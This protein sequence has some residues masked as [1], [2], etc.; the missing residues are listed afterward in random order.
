MSDEKKDVKVRKRPGRPRMAPQRE[1]IKRD[2]CVDQPM[3]NSNAM[4]LIYDNVEAIKKVFVM[5]KSMSVD[6]LKLSFEKTRLIISTSD[7]YNKSFIQVIIHGSKMNRYYCKNPYIIMLNPKNM[8]RIIHILD[9]TYITVSFISRTDELNKVLHI[10]Y[11]NDMKIDEYRELDLIDGGAVDPDV[12]IDDTGYQIKFS[13]PSR[14]FKK[15][16]CDIS[17]FTNLLTFEK[18]GTGKLSY[19]YINIDKT[20]KSK[21][22]VKD[23]NT[24][25]LVTNMSGDDIFGTTIILDYIKA[26]SGSILSPI[27][28]ISADTNKDMIFQ[29]VINNGDICVKIKTSTVNHMK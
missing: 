19:S 10:V 17:T 4:E 18:T 13:L 14:F 11:K 7:H 15:M 24:I 22:I 9:K 16:V 27:V 5:F 2:G 6:V 25:K 28:S 26:L 1:K 21:H 3:K 29:W 20:L 8:E 23:P 12:D